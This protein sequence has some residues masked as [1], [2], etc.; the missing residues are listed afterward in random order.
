LSEPQRIVTHN[1]DST[2]KFRLKA[3][4]ECIEGSMK[5]RRRNK[6]NRMGPGTRV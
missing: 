5:G 4:K 3:N 2:K 6:T 1:R